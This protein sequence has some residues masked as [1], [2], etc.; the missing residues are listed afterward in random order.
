MQNNGKINVL[1]TFDCFPIESNF[2]CEFGTVLN[3]I[4]IKKINDIQYVERIHYNN[5]ANELLKNWLKKLIIK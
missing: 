3:G 2:W 1:D 4:G 5:N